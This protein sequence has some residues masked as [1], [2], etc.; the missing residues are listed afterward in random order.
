MR[1]MTIGR[2]TGKQ[3]VAI[4]G[5]YE[6]G[7]NLI[8]MAMNGWIDGEPA[9]WLNLQQDPDTMV[10]LVDGGRPIHARAAE[11]DE[12]SRLWAK[13]REMG[14]DLDAYA[15]RRSS[16]TAVVVLEPRNR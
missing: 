13:W 2:R 10:Y 4:L 7:P 8:T 3:R 1:L 5:Y 16:G 15:M 6:D 11:G 12:R 9:W 14:A